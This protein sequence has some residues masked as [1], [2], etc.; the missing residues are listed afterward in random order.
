MGELLARLYLDPDRWWTLGELADA[1]QVPT[2]TATREATRM[3]AAGLLEEQR[4]W[5][6]RRLRINR[7]SRLAR[8]LGRLI[9][10]TYGPVPVLEDEL[11][12]LRGVNRA[13]V[14]GSWAARHE[15]VAGIEPIDVDVLIVGDPSRRDLFSAA[16]RAGKR[17][18]REVNV[19]VIPEDLWESTDRHDPFLSHVT[20]SP[21]VE[22]NLKDGR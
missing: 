11:Q 14:Y 4:V 1:A 3:A 20:S 21:L 8:P 5:R 13:F 10:L 7:N 2:P 12:G 6:T 9:E 22:L 16:E 19:S 17:L 15:G 18:H